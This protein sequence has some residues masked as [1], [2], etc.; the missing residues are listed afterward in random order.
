MTTPTTTT[1]LVI[2][3]EWIEGPH[4]GAR[5][6]AAH[7]VDGRDGRLNDW[8]DKGMR[9]IGAAEVTVSEGEGFE[10][11]RATERRADKMNY[12]EPREIVDPATGEGAGKYHFVKANKRTG[13]RPVG[14]CAEDCPGHDTPEEAA[15]HFH[16]WKLDNAIF[17]AGAD[18]PTSLHRCRYPGCEEYTAGV[19]RDQH[20]TWH[21]PLCDQ[22]RNRDGLA[23]I[24]EPSTW[25]MSSY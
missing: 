23:A 19:A 14:Y 10:L 21:H 2:Y 12:Y 16:E 25:M 20:L 4:T 5:F 17:E 8:P 13:T 7:H 24:T 18:N 15:A 9:P 22:H 3:W 11:L 6:W 1:L